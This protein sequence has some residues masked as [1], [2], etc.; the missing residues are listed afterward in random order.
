MSDHKRYEC[1]HGRLVT[2]CRCAGPKRVEVVP[3]PPTC[4]RETAYVG[5]HRVEDG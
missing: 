4:A 3:C 5:R 2:Q 1:E